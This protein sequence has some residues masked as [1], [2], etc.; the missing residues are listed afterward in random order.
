[1]GSAGAWILSVSNPSG[2]RLVELPFTPV[3]HGCGPSVL[4][5][6]GS[7][8]REHSSCPRAVLWRRAEQHLQGGMGYWTAK[9]IH[10]DLQGHWQPLP[11]AGNPFCS[12][13]GLL[14]A[15]GARFPF[16]WQMSV[17]GSECMLTPACSFYAVIQLIRDQKTGRRK[18]K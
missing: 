1:M 2:N 4:F 11:N 16:M 10:G 13:M 14:Q 7:F 15:Q 12:V 5:L 9:G 6:P 18:I 8:G 3:S 17:A